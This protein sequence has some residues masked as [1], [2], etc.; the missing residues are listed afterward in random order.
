MH[1]RSLVDTN[2]INFIESNPLDKRRSVAESIIRKYPQHIPIVIGRADIQLT[3]PINKYKYIIRRDS[4][5][6]NFIQEIR[7]DLPSLGPSTGLFFFF[8][9]NTIAPLTATM[10]TLYDKH[11]DDDGFLYLIYSCENTFG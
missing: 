11:R 1:L 10:Q 7:K 3:P 2:I 6:A 9:D 8:L 5:L 4:T